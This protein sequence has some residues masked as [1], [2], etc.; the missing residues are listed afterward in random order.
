MRHEDDSR[1]EAERIDSR[2]LL[3]PEITPD[4]AWLLG[5][6]AGDGHVS[7]PAALF[8]RRERRAKVSAGE[9]G[10][11]LCR[12]DLGQTYEDMARSMGL[13]PEQVRGLLKI[14]GLDSAR[15]HGG[16]AAVWS[17]GPV[18]LPWSEPRWGGSCA[19]TKRKDKNERKPTL[20]PAADAF[21]GQAGLGRAC[22]IAAG[23][24]SNG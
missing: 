9:V 16:R 19:A 1:K 22:K 8:E 6:I 17:V 13:K 21:G 3:F 11:V 18:L 5:L 15:Q 2:P 14:R 12:R 10:E 23:R 4:K 24:S 7:K 20:V